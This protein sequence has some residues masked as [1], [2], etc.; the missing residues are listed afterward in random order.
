MASG[1]G[2]SFGEL[3]RLRETVYRFLAAVLLRPDADWLA[4]LPPLARALGPETTAL[5]G[6]PFW[7]FW[8]RLLAA[9]GEVGDRD[10]NDDARMFGPTSADA[11]CPARESAYVRSAD[12]PRLMTDL[13]SAYS[14]AGFSLAPGFG[15]PLDHVTTELEFMSLLCAAEGE[16]WR[17]RNC[18]AAEEVLERMARAR[19][20]ELFSFMS[21]E[22]LHDVVR[23]L[24]LEL[25]VG[26]HTGEC[27]RIGDDDS[28]NKSDRE[29]CDP[30]RQRPQERHPADA[31]ER[32]AGGDQHHGNDE[33]AEQVR[34]VEHE[35]GRGSR[36]HGER[37]RGRQS[38]ADGRAEEA[39]Q[40]PASLRRGPAERRR[41]DGRDRETDDPVR[42]SRVA[43]AIDSV[44]VMRDTLQA[45][46]D[47]GL[48]DDRADRGWLLGNPRAWDPPMGWDDTI[49][50]TVPVDDEQATSRGR[51]DHVRHLLS[52][53]S[54]T[55]GMDRKEVCHV[56]PAPA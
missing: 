42:E 4:T 22:Q 41:G 53:C 16:A 52:A 9:V 15:E 10:G 54:R 45:R 23:G 49:R 25:R 5:A 1:P 8:A 12:V 32:D 46:A 19:T 17:R 21:D 30:E 6:F 24:D 31:P 34:G 20:V 18:T 43:E 51:H 39:C 35:L 40:I 27:E 36:Q 33:P 29:P 48:F 44:R 28:R 37:E 26:I 7:R 13:H 38:P 14:A 2:L 11:A 50:W 47:Y 56:R 55:S 3:A